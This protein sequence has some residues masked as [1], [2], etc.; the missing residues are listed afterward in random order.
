M[1]SGKGYLCSFLSMQYDLQVFGIDCSSV[2]THG[3]QERNRKLKKFSRAYQR[4]SSNK[5]NHEDSK[6]ENEEN[7]SEW[8]RAPT[9]PE[10]RVTEESEKER[11]IEQK[12]HPITDAGNQIV[13]VQGCHSPERTSD[14]LS[15]TSGPTDSTDAD[16]ENSFFIALSPDIME[17]ATPRIP[18][19]QLSLEE[20]ERRKREN[21]ERKAR[22]RRQNTDTCLFSPLT[23]YVTA[24]TELRTLITE[25]EVRSQNYSSTFTNGE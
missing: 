3:A 5:H 4:H 20:R 1:G 19:S 17:Q 6:K 21:L 12:N 2:N 22:D 24:E 8:P 9:D 23:S 14:P 11:G 25:L 13:E 18:P 10:G 16:P 7:C 15:V